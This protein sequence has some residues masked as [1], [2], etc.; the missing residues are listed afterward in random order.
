MLMQMIWNK[1]IIK[2]ITETLI[3]TK[4]NKLLIKQEIQ[5]L[6]KNNLFLIVH[7]INKF[8]LMM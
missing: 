8:K 2:N 1:I 5:F 3:L 6:Q 4:K 7:K